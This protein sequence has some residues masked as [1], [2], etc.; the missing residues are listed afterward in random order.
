MHHLPQADDKE[1]ILRY[2][3]LHLINVVGYR[4]QLKQCVLCHL[5]LQPVTNSFSPGAGG[6]LCPRC[7]R[8]QPLTYSVTVDGQKVLRWLQDSG[9]ETV[10]RQKINPELSRQIERIMRGYLKYLMEREVKS[11]AWL[12]T[13]KRERE[14]ILK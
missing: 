6:M 10:T 8:N 3:E 9:C 1:L 12:D 5:S 2:F 7:S 4:P 14:M 11:A 13:L